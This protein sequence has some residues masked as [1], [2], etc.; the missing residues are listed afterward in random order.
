MNV[1]VITGKSKVV[2]DNAKRH[3]AGKGIAPFT[4]NLGAR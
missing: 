4:L 2:P 1:T 3:I